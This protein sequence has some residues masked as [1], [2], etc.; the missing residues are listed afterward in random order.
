M[1]TISTHSPSLHTVS[2]LFFYLKDKY[3]NTNKTAFAYKPDSNQPYKKI[4][5]ND[6]ATDVLSL[7]NY[8]FSKNQKKE[9][10]IGLL[11]ENRYEWV[12]ADMACQL[13]GLITVPIY[14]SFPKEQCQFILTHSDCSLCFVSTQIQLNKIIAIKSQCPQLKQVIVFKLQRQLEHHH[15]Y[16]QTYQKAIEY[17]K[18][19]YLIHKH[20]II[21][22]AKE[23]RPTDILTIIYTLWNNR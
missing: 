4:T 6:Y 19:T 22:R 12:V 11:S 20:D 14:P 17:G 18:K 3:Q 16:I 9:N 1:S 5:W 13:L 21:Q 2:E 23:I 10:R 7:S 15:Q 8:L